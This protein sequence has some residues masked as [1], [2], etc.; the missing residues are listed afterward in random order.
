[1]AI[2]LNSHATH[3]LRRESCCDLPAMAG[4]RTCERPTARTGEAPLSGRG[5][6]SHDSRRPR[7]RSWDM[8]RN[9]ALTLG[10][11]SA[12]APRYLFK[13]QI[14]AK[15]AA[16]ISPDCRAAHLQ[17]TDCVAGHMR[18]EL[19]NVVPNCPFERSHR[20]GGIQPNSGHRDYSRLSFSAVD[21]QLGPEKKGRRNSGINYFRRIGFA[22]EGSSGILKLRLATH[23]SR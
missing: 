10:W 12:S 20:F 18:L 21:T 7:K 17:E 13:G 19:R 8:R 14:S 23:P 5:R 9:R 2:L 11:A 16:D 22:P 4:P 6:S 3:T 15:R 1:M